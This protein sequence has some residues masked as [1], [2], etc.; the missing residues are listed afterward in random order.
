ML[1]YHVLNIC[2]RCIKDA[3]LRYILQSEGA[4]SQKGDLEGSN[5]RFEDYDSRNLHRGQ[6]ST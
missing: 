2:D 1:F 3:E 4:H 6:M 5:L